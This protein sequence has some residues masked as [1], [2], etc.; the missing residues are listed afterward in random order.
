MDDFNF[1]LANPSLV[2]QGV[3]TQDF[4]GF[5]LNTGPTLAVGLGERLQLDPIFTDNELLGLGFV[6]IDRPAPVD[7]VTRN[8]G[9]SRVVIAGALL[10]V[11][12]VAFAAGRG[13]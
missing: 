5:N 9:A 2:L 4:N 10:A 1:N 3:E 7:I 11:G 8:V 13:K 6:P 12:I